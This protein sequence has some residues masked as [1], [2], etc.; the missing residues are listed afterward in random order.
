MVL[1]MNI[2]SSLKNLSDHLSS[3]A[4]ISSAT[5][6]LDNFE[7]LFLV[8]FF[9][10]VT[11]FLSVATFWSERLVFTSSRIWTDPGFI[12]CGVAIFLSLNALQMGVASWD[13]WSEVK[14]LRSHHISTTPMFRSWGGHD[15]YTIT[16]HKIFHKIR[17]LQC[18]SQKKY[19]L[20]QKAS[21]CTCTKRK[22][23]LWHHIL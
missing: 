2:A 23:I 6:E 13:F 17:Y 11:Y 7:D 21:Q 9:A 3:R 12:S 8:D 5:K 1:A 10:V 22:K 15:I 19:I 18:I 16:C 20:L 14:E 4:L